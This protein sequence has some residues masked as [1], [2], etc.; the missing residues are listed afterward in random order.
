LE[1]RLL[2]NTRFGLNITYNEWPVNNKVED[3][4]IKEMV[5]LN[6]MYNFERDLWSTG[7]QWIAG[8]DEVG[9]GPLAGPVVAAAVILPGGTWLPGVN[10]SK[11]IPPNRRIELAASIK[12]LAIAYKVAIVEVDY[13]DRF[14]IRQGS[15]E[16]MRQAVQGLG[17][18]PEYLLVDGMSIP[19]I[20]IPQSGLV[21]GDTRSASIAAA[22]I[23]AKVVRDELMDELDL[24]YPGY[25]FC[26]HKG[27]ATPEHLAALAKIGPCPI[28]RWS[29]APVRESAG[30]VKADDYFNSVS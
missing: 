20:S 8:I 29:F 1:A 7:H 11:K 16:A 30:E 6:Q 19:D 2:K 28:H 9:R 10:D 15:L 24:I 17:V 18:H 12:E 4:W 25:G 23:L 13:I 27:Y 21:R 26:R 14:N 3:F 5:R 22:S